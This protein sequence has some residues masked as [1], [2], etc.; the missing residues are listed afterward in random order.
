MSG[1]AL[2]RGSVTTRLADRSVIAVD[3]VTGGRSVVP[4]VD[5]VADHGA[6]ATGQLDVR[7]HP[8]AE[9]HVGERAFGTTPLRP[10]PTLAVGRYRVR[11][12]HE[13]DERTVDVVVEAGKATP[14]RAD[15]SSGG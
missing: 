2:G 11:L 3:I 8:W 9:V 12:V 10:L 15:F 4:I 1:T 6:L 5:G 7:V 14:V 13:A